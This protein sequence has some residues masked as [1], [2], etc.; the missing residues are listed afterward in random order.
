MKW[1][2][3]VV[4]NNYSANS[5]FTAEHGL[6]MLLRGRGASMGKNGEKSL[7]LLID[8]ARTGSVLMSN[9]TALDVQPEEIDALLLSHGHYD[10]TGGLEALLDAR[11]VPLPIFVHPHAFDP[12][13][14]FHTGPR[15]ISAGVDR[16]AIAARGGRVHEIREAFRLLPEVIVLGEIPRRHEEEEE[17]RAGMYCTREGVYGPDELLDDTSIALRLEGG[18]LF[19]VCGCCHSGL[20]NTIEYAL[21]LSGETELKGMIGGLHTIHA[22]ERRM[23]FT[24]EKLKEYDPEA[25][26]PL[27]CAGF[28]ETAVLYRELGEKVG[29]VSTG[30]VVD[31]DHLFG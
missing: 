20:I 5:R 15:D 19:L 12:K 10:H 8:T 21:E 16:E 14:S 17:A 25:I 9:L 2:I 26:L 27:H 30:A 23:K 3:S 22:G 13:M 29:F 4:V 6:S 18:G 11:E 7:D 24:V 1:T 31:I 28:R